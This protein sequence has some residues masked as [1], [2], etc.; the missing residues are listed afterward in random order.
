M[1]PAASQRAEGTGSR[2]RQPVTSY[3]KWDRDAYIERRTSL[4]GKAGK[5]VPN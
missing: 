5:P 4:D 1:N 2:G 3:T